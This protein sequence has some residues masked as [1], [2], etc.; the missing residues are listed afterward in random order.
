MGC[1]G[2]KLAQKRRQGLLLRT[3]ET[4]E[5]LFQILRVLGAV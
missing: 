1:A 5:G 3:G 4:C 2:P